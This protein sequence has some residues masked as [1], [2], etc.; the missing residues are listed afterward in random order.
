MEINN[1]RTSTDELP[2]FHK[3]LQ[4]N[5]QGLCRQ[6]VPD[7]TTD[8]AQRLKAHMEQERRRSIT[9]NKNRIRGSS[10]TGHAKK[11][12]FVLI[13]HRCVGYGK[14]GL[15]SQRVNVE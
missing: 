6:S 1:L 4:A 2:W 12:R 14:I 3:L 15:F 9:E 10:G 11:E 5:H 13:R 7:E 8:T